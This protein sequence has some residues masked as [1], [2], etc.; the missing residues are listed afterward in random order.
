MDS[1]MQ[2]N[3]PVESARP[4]SVADS[5]PP[6]RVWIFVYTAT[7]LVLLLMTAAFY[8]AQ[9]D[10]VSRVLPKDW[11]RL[12]ATAIWFAMLGGVAINLKGLYDHQKRSD[13]ATGSWTLWYLGRPFSTAVVGITVYTA[14][15]VINP[16]TPPAAAALA[17]ACFTMGT[18]ERRFFN[19]VNEVAKLVLS[20]PSTPAT[21]TGTTSQPTLGGNSGAAPSAPEALPARPLP[22]PAGPKLL[23]GSGGGP[24]SREQVGQGEAADAATG[25][26]MSDHGGKILQHVQVQLLFWGVAWTGEATPS[27]TD[28][29]NAVERIMTGPYLSAL[30][31]YRNIGTGRLGG[32]VV[33]SSSDPPNPFTDRDMA[34]LVRAQ[35]RA[36]TVPEPDS[37]AGLLYCVVLPPG[38]RAADPRVIGEHSY[39]LYWDVDLP[40]DLDVGLVHY[41]WVMNDGTLDYVTTV[42]SHELVESCTDPEGTAVT[43][44]PG[45]CS[46]S[47]WCEIGDVC[48]TSQSLDGVEV[49]SYWSQRD[50]ACIIPGLGAQTTS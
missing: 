36:G 50:R 20:V 3:H 1:T 4:P 40:F 42:F 44:A 41:A 27:V 49:Q 6:A 32:H 11:Q 38:V 33:I 13:W 23:L 9:P 19:F 29:T 31:Q 30:S 47:G 45:S 28:I 25:V 7:E 22:M 17:V 18:Q 8:L 35:L 21:P 14:F 34:Q 39:F 5:P 43:G 48:I 24:V 46:G 15:Q 2:R 10:V 26:V 12:A 16:G 37:D